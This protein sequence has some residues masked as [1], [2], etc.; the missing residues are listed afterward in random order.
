MIFL[1][2]HEMISND[3]LYIQRLKVNLTKKGTI[4][5]VI[6]TEKRSRLATN[7]CNF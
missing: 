7:N 4:N 3:D 5:K 6:L 2:H 1:K